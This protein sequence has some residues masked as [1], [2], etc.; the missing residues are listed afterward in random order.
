MT[1]NIILIL[2]SLFVSLQVD[3][4]SQSVVLFSFSC[5][6]CLQLIVIFKSI[7]ASIE[8]LVVCDEV[9]LWLYWF[10]WRRLIISYRLC[11][12]VVQ[13]VLAFNHSTMHQIIEITF[14]SSTKA[15]I[16]LPYLPIHYPLILTT[17]LLTKF[18]L[19]YFLLAKHYFLISH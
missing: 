14:D 18:S 12:I 17:K 7:H 5:G 3:D 2:L 8:F 6:L 1:C 11:L 13:L 4:N 16:I 19:P 10:I 9:L 15:N